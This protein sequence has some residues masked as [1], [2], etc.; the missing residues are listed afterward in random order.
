MNHNPLLTMQTEQQAFRQATSVCAT[1]AGWNRLCGGTVIAEYTEMETGKLAVSPSSKRF[2][3]QHLEK[4]GSCLAWS[5]APSLGFR[6]SIGTSGCYFSRG[7]AILHLWI[8]TTPSIHWWSYETFGTEKAIDQTWCQ[9]VGGLTAAACG[10]G[11]C[12][13]KTSAADNGNRG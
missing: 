6:K 8:G 7:S 5:S 1:D 9:A 11:S 13:G 4:F 10:S 12:L 2:L 3:M